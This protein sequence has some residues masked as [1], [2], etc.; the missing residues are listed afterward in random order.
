M[1][2]RAILLLLLFSSW[3]SSAHAHGVDHTVS[4]E[5]AIVLRLSYRSGGPFADAQVEIARVGEKG[6][7]FNGRTDARGAVAFLPVGEGP[8]RCRA[9]SEDGHGTQFTF[10]APTRGSTIDL[11]A[12]PPAGKWR[13]IGVGLGVIALL[14]AGLTWWSTRR[15]RVVA[16]GGTGG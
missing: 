16:R 1:V 3:S 15:S 12:R 6:P 2:G 14:F 11:S 13:E 4:R 5:D 7:L 8:W 10:E 9:F